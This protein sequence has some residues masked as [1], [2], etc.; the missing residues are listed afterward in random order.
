MNKLVKT[1]ESRRTLK[2]KFKIVRSHNTEITGKIDV[3]KGLYEQCPTCKEWKND[4]AK[5]NG[6][7]GWI[8]FRKNL[9]RSFQSEICISLIQLK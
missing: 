3:P 2:S 6:Y 1:F 9:P 8:V 4:L 7:G 5:K